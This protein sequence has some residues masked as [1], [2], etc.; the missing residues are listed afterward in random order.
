MVGI[1]AL[2]DTPLYSGG[3][4]SSTTPRLYPVSINGRGYVIDFS[5]QPRREIY[6]H[7]SIPM[8]R[9]QADTSNVPGQQSLNPDG[10]W[11]R[12]QES[13]HGGA[14][15]SHLDRVTG[16]QSTTSDETRFRSSKGVD[17]WTKWQ[18]SLLPA[19]ASVRT[20]SNTNLALVS[21]GTRLYI[22]DGQ[23]LLYATTA[24][25][26]TSGTAVTGT[27]AATASSVCSDGYNVYVAY[28]GSGLYTTNRG[29]GAATQLVTTALTANSICRYVKG[30]LLV[31]KD[32]SIYNVTSTAPAA[33][34]TA[35]LTHPNTDFVWVDCAEG[36][37]HLYAAGY[38]GD[39]SLI[40]KTSVKADGTALDVPQVAGE[41]PDGE[42]ISAIQGYLGFLMIGTN[43]GVHFAQ[44]DTDGNV[45]LGD[46]IPTSSSVRC[47]EPQDR[48]VWFGWTDYDTTSTGL[49]RM[50]L[51]TLNGSAP[52]YASDLMATAQGAVTSV[53]TFGNKRVFAVSA[54]G[55]HA[56]QTTRVASGGTLDSGFITFGIVDPKVA[57][58]IHLDYAQL[59]G[60]IETSI[61]QDDGP[62][63]S[64]GVAS[65]IGSTATDFPT[66]QSLT[67]H[68]E[69]RITLTGDSSATT[70]SAA[71]TAGSGQVSSA[72]G[73]VL[74]RYT[75]RANPAAN[76]GYSISVPI[77]LAEEMLVGGVD[78]PLVPSIELYILDQLRLSRQIVPFQEG[79]SSYNVTVEAIDWFPES[80]GRENA[81]FN[82]VA[83]VDL[84]TLS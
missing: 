70:G 72:N 11:R 76:T 81:E 74:N 50:D 14:G 17:V 79:S 5:T 3:A 52:A 29:S 43:Q 1:S 71:T 2:L 8:M 44:I 64:A 48:F 42:I 31:S 9:S 55:F 26:L 35:L 80:L 60:M 34:P 78:I 12:S 57:A 10:L 54:S 41:L 40:Y 62:F 82:G 46:L 61:S 33:L 83:V 20:S 38:S 36:P 4:V 18:L 59:Y 30:R 27:P 21:V 67:D 75:L 84:K 65:G 28:A 58:F 15:Q 24:A 63:M 6:R 49:G 51:R 68:F 47:F 13:W 45:I 16:S 23:S 69:V 39:K 77:R 37:A 32:N 25:G 66:D 22:I 19:T 73:P 53:V 56:E 7:Q